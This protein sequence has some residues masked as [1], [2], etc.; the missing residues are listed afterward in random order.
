MTNS[1]LLKMAHR[2]SS[3]T[4]EKDRDFPVRELL[5]YQSV[6]PIKSHYIDPIKPP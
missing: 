3:F 4:Y 5:V 1:L 6:N 2:H